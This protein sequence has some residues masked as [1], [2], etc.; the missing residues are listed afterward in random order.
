MNIGNG[1][2]GGYGQRQMERDVVDHIPPRELGKWV[3][4]LWQYEDNEKRYKE[5]CCNVFDKI[6]EKDGRKGIQKT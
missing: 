6:E 1:I 2:I 5:R 4:Y 3:N